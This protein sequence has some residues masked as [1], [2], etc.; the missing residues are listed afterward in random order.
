MVA[1][2]QTRGWTGASRRREPR[3]RLQSPLDVTVSRAGTTEVVPGRA[4]NVCERGVGAVV[5]GELLPGETVGIELRLASARHSLK[6]Q[7]IVRYQ[8]KLRCGLEFAPITPEQKLVI[9]EWARNV[10]LGTELKQIS[11]QLFAAEEKG[12]ISGTELTRQNGPPP[13]GG[14]EPRRKPGKNRA[15]KV[16]IG[17]LILIAIAAGIFGWK[18]NHDWEQLEGGLNRPGTSEPEK[19]QAQVPAEVMQRLLVHR[20]E[21]VYPTEARKQNVEGVIVL[22]IVVGRDGS[23]VSMRALNGPAVLSKAAMDALRWWKF[24]PYRVN[25][26][27]AVVETTIAVEFKKQ[28]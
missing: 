8:D 16:W 9:E 10:S 18:W 4:L 20:V 14:D 6:T 11:N 21:P 13:P 3:F 22:D 23:V 17:S 27:P 1:T 7:A 25:G 12:R 28:P 15:R 5:A 24:E 19:P 2:A 26:V